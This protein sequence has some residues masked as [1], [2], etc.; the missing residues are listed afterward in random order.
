MYSRQSHI[1][2]KIIIHSWDSYNSCHLTI[3][4]LSETMPSHWSK[5]LRH[6]SCPNQCCQLIKM[7]TVNHPVKQQLNRTDQYLNYY[8][9]KWLCHFEMN[10]SIGKQRCY[11]LLRVPL[12]ALHLTYLNGGCNIDLYK[13][14]RYCTLMILCS[15]K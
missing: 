13:V 8:C 15:D 9:N 1:L 12:W 11:W 3:F 2:E 7:D 5:V 6:L 14:C 4:P 10:C